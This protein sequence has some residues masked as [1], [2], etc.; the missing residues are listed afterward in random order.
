MQNIKKWFQ[1]HHEMVR[2][3]PWFK[4][5]LIF[6]DVIFIGIGYVVSSNFGLVL[7]LLGMFLNHLLSPIIVQRVFIKELNA[8]LRMSG[9]LETKV[10]R[11]QDDDMQT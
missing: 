10:I 3:L 4:G 5:V 1:L 2:K 7:S 8:K 11:K 9:A 6:I